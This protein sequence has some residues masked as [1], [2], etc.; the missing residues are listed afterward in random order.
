MAVPHHRSVL[1]VH[2]IARF[3]GTGTVSSKLIERS[4][5]LPTKLDGCA[6]TRAGEASNLRFFSTFFNF[7]LFD[8]K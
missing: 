5:G 4:I 7:N 3:N 8:I 6:H 1:R 2:N